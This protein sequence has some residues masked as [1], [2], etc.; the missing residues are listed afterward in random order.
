[1]SREQEITFYTLEVVAGL[2]RLRPALIERCTEIGIVSP[3]RDEDEPRYSPSDVVR[4]RRVRRFIEELGLNW[5]GVEVVMR[6]QDEMA[7]MYAELEE[8]RVFR[9]RYNR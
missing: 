2:T 7:K 1:M 8:L 9:Q 4:L 5:A 3:S 6:L